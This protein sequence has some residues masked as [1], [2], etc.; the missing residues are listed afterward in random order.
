[1]P[2]CERYEITVTPK[3]PSYP[4]LEAVQKEKVPWET[5][6]QGSPNPVDYRY[7]ANIPVKTGQDDCKI[8]AEELQEYV[9]EQWQKY[10]KPIENWRGKSLFWSGFTPAP[11][12]DDFLKEVDQALIKKLPPSAPRHTEAKALCIYWWYLFPPKEIWNA[13]SPSQQEEWLLKL[14]EIKDLGM[15]PVIDY[16]KT[17]GGKGI[18][19]QTTL[20]IGFSSESEASFT[21]ATRYHPVDVSLYL[22]FQKAGVE[23]HLVEIVSNE[24]NSFNTCNSHIVVGNGAATYQNGRWRGF[25]PTLAEDH[26][27]QWPFYSLS[28]YQLSNRGFSSMEDLKKMGEELALVAKNATAE[29]WKALLDQYHGDPFILSSLLM[30]EK[31]NGEKSPI[32]DNTFIEMLTHYPAFPETV[33]TLAAAGIAY[34]K[35]RTDMAMKILKEALDKDPSCLMAAEAIAHILGN[36]EKWEQAE[37][38]YEQA[39]KMAM[40]PEDHGMDFY[41]HWGFLAIQL[42]KYPEALSRFD[43]HLSRPGST[44]ESR[45]LA[46]LYKAVAFAKMEDFRQA[47]QALN[48]IQT[49]ELIP[50]LERLEYL[51]D[52]W[53]SVSKE[54]GF[55]KA[56]AQNETLKNHLVQMYIIW[57]QAFALLGNLEKTKEWYMAALK[58]SPEDDQISR[59]L[60]ELA[61]WNME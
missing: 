60:E 43:Q 13:L 44:P 52:R 16:L 38:V 23:S 46:F 59:Q 14:Q 30:V 12:W 47:F 58:L 4:L 45:Q 25:R 54:D 37:A 18:Y 15:D 39:E 11:D 55:E 35:D 53:Q 51:T 36:S 61:V 42:E 56:L 21:I 31:K 50:T 28:L 17:N 29:N 27:E 20:K 2:S 22:Y 1:M 57:G 49:I 7:P 9:V 33:R 32:D 34:R 3:D 5:V 24:E 40:S 48:Q 26:A 19:F 10:A 8:T 41:R 6:D